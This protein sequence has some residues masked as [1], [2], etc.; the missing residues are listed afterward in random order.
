MH[1]L[2]SEPDE[3]REDPASQAPIPEIGREELPEELEEK[4]RTLRSLRVELAKLKAGTKDVE[5]AL[6]SND[7]LENFLSKPSFTD[8]IKTGT[9]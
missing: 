9:R 6:N 3:A 7:V 5:G 8:L 1:D 4:T 2:E